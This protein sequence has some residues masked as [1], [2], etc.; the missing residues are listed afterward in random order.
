MKILKRIIIVLL[1]IIA[2]PLLV[3]L[4]VSKEFHSERE[5]VIDKPSWEVFDYIKY[6]KNQDN[7][8]VWQLSDP[9]AKFKEEGTDGTVGYKY[10]W[11]GKKVGKGTQS[12]TN[13][14]HNE[15]LETELDFGFGEPAQSYILTEEVSPDQTKVTWG[16]SGKT[17]YPWNL[18][19]L[20]YDMG[21]DFEGGLENLKKILEEQKSP[22]DRA[23][24]LNY[25][26]KTMDDLKNNVSDL[27]AG[28]LHFRPS[29]TVW[30]ISQC[31]E[32]II[33]TEAMIFGMLKENMNKPVNP[34]RRAEIKLYDKDIIAMVTDRSEKYKAPEM[35]IGKGKYDDAKQALQDLEAQ[36]TEILSFINN[37]PLEELRNRVSDS[38]AGA[39]DA[40]QSLL[41]IAGHTARH[42]LQ[43]EEI[44]N[45]QNFPAQ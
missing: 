22:D 10:S 9:E 36:R 5:I 19:G 3:A 32:H 39:T 24:A 15:K 8:G 11:D 33:L 18:M 4:F 17:P 35:L 28:Q 14:L 7:Y 27:S 23:F 1:I 26:Q 34:E 41:F 12:I 16:I 13:V 2:I 42:T 25:Y 45:A 38:P 43:I 31:L 29:D 37:T 44:K 6:V 21:K 30:S 20:F 40:Y